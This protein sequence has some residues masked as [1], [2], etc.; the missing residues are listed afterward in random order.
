MM[1]KLKELLLQ[2][3]AGLGASTKPT[4]YAGVSALAG[5]VNTHTLT[6]RL[7]DEMPRCKAMG[8]D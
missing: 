3:L 7:G 4:L 6:E 8:N 1:G 2:V 5:M